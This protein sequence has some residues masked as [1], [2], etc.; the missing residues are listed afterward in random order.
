MWEGIKI[1]AIF[2]GVLFSILTVSVYLTTGLIPVV[3][4]V[5]AIIWGILGI[6]SYIKSKK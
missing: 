5:S 1:P 2:G 3:P 4:F 6:V